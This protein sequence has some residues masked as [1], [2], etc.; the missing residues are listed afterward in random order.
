MYG[1]NPYDD[2]DFANLLG[3]LQQS[4]SMPQITQGLL[5][6]NGKQEEE[7][8]DLAERGDQA[9]AQMAQL[10]QTQMPANTSNDLAQRQAMAQQSAM[11]AAMQQQQQQAQAGNLL[12]TI[13]SLFIPGGSVLN[14]FKK[15]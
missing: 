15:K 6:G 5:L 12:G 7:L 8:R 4:S 1:Y 3:S 14:Y 13:A 11:Q 2:I 10:A 9:A